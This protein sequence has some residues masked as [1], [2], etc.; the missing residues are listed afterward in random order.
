M[1]TSGFRPAQHRVLSIAMLA[2]GAD[3]KVTG[4]FS[5]LLNPGCD[6]GPV[7]VHGLTPQ[8][9]AGAP[10]F[11]QIAPDVAA[12]LQGRV[13]VA[14]NARFDYDFLAEEFARAGLRLPV[15]QRLC[16][17]ALNR[18]LAPPTRNMRLGT[19]AAH[20]GVTQRKA[21]DAED[22]TRVLAGV[23]NGS[24]TAAAQ[25]GLSLPLVPCPP[26]Q[27]SSRNRYPAAAPKV[28]CPYRNPG[29]LSGGGPLVQGMKVAVTGDTR[30]PRS[31]LTAKAGAAGLNVMS[32]VSRHTSVLV[33]NAP[34]PPST[35]TKRAVAE[36]VPI[37]DEAAFLSLLQDVRPGTGHESATPPP[38]QAAPPAQAAV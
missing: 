37:I 32:S 19:L 23:L 16:T 10:K 11:E 25:L 28:P 5:S 20:Y 3:G 1:E 17:L 21:H 29:R 26:R 7:H 18:R 35:K 22:D 27:T 2:V 24:L 4:R 34:N 15:E 31:E 6:P 38:P 33:T 12:L 8:R 30:T 36:G 14:H 9:L 13:M